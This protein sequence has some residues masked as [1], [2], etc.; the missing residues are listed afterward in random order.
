MCELPVRP[1][2]N[3]RIV[4]IM[5]LAILL[6]TYNGERYLEAQIESLLAQTFSAFDL[7]IR[8]D[9]STDATPRIIDDFERKYPNIHRV[10]SVPGSLGAYRNFMFLLEHADADYY[11]FCDQDDVWM[12]DKIQ[13]SMDTIRELEKRYPGRAALIFTDLSLVGP[14]L[15]MI[16]PSSWKITK[17]DPELALKYLDGSC[18]MAG[19]TM[20]F[21]RAAKAVSLPASANGWIHDY[22]VALNV[23]RNGAI[24]YV[25]RPTI[26]YRQHG[27]N[28]IGTT[29]YPENLIWTKLKG[30]RRMMKIN[31]K[32]YRMVRHVT[33]TSLL[34]YWMTKIQ[35]AVHRRK[36]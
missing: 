7:Y 17:T 33:G 25:N 28:V 15:E 12:A 23:A 9:G 13:V 31:A 29:A 32:S 1:V 3:G 22:W 24:G 35:Y 6:A 20:L 8:D 5:S 2:W 18:P 4:N 11:M 16:A 36:L 26:L 14:R 10:T 21:N 19:C 34:G 30:F 27:N